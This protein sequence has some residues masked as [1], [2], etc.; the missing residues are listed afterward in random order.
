MGVESITNDNFVPDFSAK[1]IGKAKLLKISRADYRKKIADI[2]NR[3]W[4][5]N[6]NE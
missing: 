1:I 3:R 4:W 2:K 6:F 5:N